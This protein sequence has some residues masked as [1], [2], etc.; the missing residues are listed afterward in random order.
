[1]AGSSRFVLAALDGEASGIVEKC[2]ATLGRL[3]EA[4]VRSVHVVPGVGLRGELRRSQL[5]QV[6]RGDSQEVVGRP[7]DVLARL[8]QVTDCQAAVFAMRRPR[9][10]ERL[11]RG[12]GTALAVARRVHRPLLL[13]PPDMADWAGPHKAL[14]VLDGTGTTAMASA[15]AL[16]DFAALG[17]R[18][19]PVHAVDD[20]PSQPAPRSRQILD[21]QQRQECDLIVLAWLRQMRGADGTAVVDVLARTTVPVLLVPADELVGASA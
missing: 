11:R 8:V 1:M 2:A 7:E 15:E 21:H 20:D 17:V 16:A 9:P 4:P 14:V 6:L 12:S 19:V 13:V 10:G 18:S 3:L 5:A